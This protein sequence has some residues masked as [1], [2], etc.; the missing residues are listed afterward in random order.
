M[1]M[2]NSS[3]PRSRAAAAR[4]SAGSITAAPAVTRV[5]SKVMEP[6]ALRRDTTSPGTPSSD[7]STFE[8]PPST[9]NG[10]APSAAHDA[11]ALSS[12]MVEGVAK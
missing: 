12:S 1:P 8:P 6:Q 9:R 2:A 3:P 10:S 4:A 7:T 5:P 11:S